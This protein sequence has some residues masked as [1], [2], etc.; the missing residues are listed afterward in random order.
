MCK[1]SKL[2]K[3]VISNKIDKLEEELEEDRKRLAEEREEM[4]FSK[5]VKINTDLKDLYN[6]QKKVN[7]K[8][9]ELLSFKKK[10][11]N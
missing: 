9:K 3:K 4:L 1:Y 7:D 11:L 10:Y 6:V 2:K 5:K 8:Y